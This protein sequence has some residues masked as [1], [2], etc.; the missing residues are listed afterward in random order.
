MPGTQWFPGAHVNYAEHVLRHERPNATAVSASLRTAQDHGP[1]VVGRARP[2]RCACSPRSSASSGEARRSRRCV[3]AEHSRS[4]D[5][6]ARDDEHRRHLVELRA[7]L[8]HARR[9]GSL[10]A[11]VTEDPARAWTATSMA[12]SRS[13]R[14]KRRWGRSSKEL[15]TLE[16]VIH[17]PYPESRGPRRC[18]RRMRCSGTIAVRSSARA[19]ERV[20]VRARRRSM[21]RCGFRFPG[22]T[23]GLPKAIT[24]SHGGIILEQIEGPASDVG[25]A[26]PRRRCM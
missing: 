14:R 22:G 9:A 1:T 15:S 12:A 13:S 10:H 25:P 11:V 26:S 23:T 2:A 6:D 24:H 16:R 17:V 5:R 19:E 7:G 4:D 18:P 8:R 3:P 21:R 20:Q